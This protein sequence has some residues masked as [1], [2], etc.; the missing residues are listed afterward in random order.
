MGAGC[1]ALLPAAGVQQPGSQRAG[2][3]GFR[4]WGWAWAVCGAGLWQKV[5]L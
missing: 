2:I 3:D 4:A 5:V 1:D